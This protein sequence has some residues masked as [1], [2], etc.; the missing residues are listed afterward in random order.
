MQSCL[1]GQSRERLIRPRFR[2]AQGASLRDDDGVSDDD[3]AA[4]AK[5]TWSDA[6]GEADAAFAANAPRPTDACVASRQIDRQIAVK[7][8]QEV[9]H[10]R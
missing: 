9:A 2:F 7:E 10:K 6:S 3:A 1:R 4:N 8:K 5:A